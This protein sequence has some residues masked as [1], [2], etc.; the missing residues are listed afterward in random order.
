[1][2]VGSW[3]ALYPP[4]FPVEN[5]DNRAFIIGSLLRL[6]GSVT[7]LTIEIITGLRDDLIVTTKINVFYFYFLFLIPE[8]NFSWKH[9]VFFKVFIRFWHYV[10][11]NFT[12]FSRPKWKNS[13]KIV[14]FTI[15][16]DEFKTVCHVPIYLFT[17]FKKN[18][19]PYAKHFDFFEHTRVHGWLFYIILHKKKKKCP[20]LHVLCKIIYY[21]NRKIHSVSKKMSFLFICK[22]SSQ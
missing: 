15:E 22:K 7:I 21:Q 18:L 9:T 6:T 4:D 3:L 1:M 20:L 17:F 12:E 10:L 2:D 19:F 11:C 13:F 16:D 14:D 8:L 5:P